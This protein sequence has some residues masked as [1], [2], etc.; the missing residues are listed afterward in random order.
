MPKHIIRLIVL[1]A[2]FGGV[3][4]V[5]RVFFVDDSFYLYGHYRGDS[6]AEIA[7]DVP[8]YRGTAYCQSCHTARY[9]EWSAG[10]HNSAD[11]KKVVKCE[12]CHGAAGG[13]KSQGIAEHPASSVDHPAGVKLAIPKDTVKLC[14]LCH[15]AMPGRPVEQRQIDVAKHAGTQQCIVCHNPHSPKINFAAAAAKAPT[16]NAAAGKAVSAACAGC[17]GAAGVSANPAWPNLAGQHASYLADALKAFKSGVRDNAIMSGAAKN[18]S[19]V[20]MQNVAA[21]FANAKCKTAGGATAK[22]EAEA[23]ASKA[24]TAAC[25]T[26]HGVNGISGNPAWPSL[27]GQNQDY[28][29]GALKAFKDGSRNSA[30]MGGIAKDLSAADI[31]NLAGYYATLSCRLSQ[32]ESEQRRAKND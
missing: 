17:H 26:C 13:R 23:G 8:K 5:A 4:Y 12:A 31:D 18:L 28:L 24:K 2:A 6:V 1:I 29:A 14:T 16:G 20:E 11:I 32:P 21:Y 3:A 19:E 15:E 30:V 7:S 27:A 22:A 25:A 10:I 9:N